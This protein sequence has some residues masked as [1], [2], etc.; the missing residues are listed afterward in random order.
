VT[1]GLRRLADAG[2]LTRLSQD[3]W[4]LTDVA[5]ERLREPE[6]LGLLEA[7]EAIDLPEL[8]DEP[9]G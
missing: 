9:A 8:E 3:R 2:L 7:V 6:S 5:V 4:L 1:V